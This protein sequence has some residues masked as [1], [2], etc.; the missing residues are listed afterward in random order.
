MHRL[1]L[2]IFIALL[3]FS[4]LHLHASAQAAGLNITEIKIDGLQRVEEASVRKVLKSN[5]GYPYS[6]DMISDD[7]R[8]IYKLGYFSDVIVAKEDTDEGIRL[9]YTIRERPSIRNVKLEGN[10]DV[11]DDDIEEVLDVKKHQV[12]SYDKLKRNAEKIRNVYIDKGFFLADVDFKVKEVDE[13][14]VDVV[15]VMN[16][17]AKV[18]VKKIILQGNKKI[19]DKE[20]LGVMMTKVADPFSFINNSGKFRQEILERDAFMIGNYYAD[21]GYINAKVSPPEV[22]ISPDRRWIYLTIKIQEGESYNMGEVDFQGELIFPKENLHKMM[23]LKKGEVFNRSIF[24]R[25]MEAVANLYKDKGY[26]YANVTPLTT[27]HK[28]E[29]IVDVVFDIERGQKVYIERI[30]IVGNTK[31][32]DKVIRREMRISEGDLYSATGINQ[33]KRRIYQ[34]GYF[35]TV[36]VTERP[37]SGPDNIILTV[38]VK[39]QRTGTFQLGFGFSSLENFVFQSQISQNNLLGRGQTLSLNAQVSGVR[40]QFQL[41]FFEP[42]T[43]DTKIQTGFTVFN[44]SY[45]YPRQGDFGTYSRTMWGGDFTI[46]YPFWDDVALYL[47]YE[48]KRVDMDVDNLVHLHLFKDGL[49][50]SFT[51]TAQWDTRDNRLYPTDGMLHRFSVEYADS[52]TG[53]D[54][55]FLKLTLLDNIFIPIWWKFVFKLNLEIGYVTSLE[56]PFADKRGGKDF[57]GVPLAERYLLGGIYSI[58]GFEYGSISPSIDVIPQDDPAGYPVRYRIGGNKQLITNWEIEFPV[59]EQAGVK[60]VFFFDAGNTWAEDEQFF[61]LGQSDVNEWDL[62]L[63]LYMSCGFG[64]R[65]YS[66]MGPLRFEWGIPITK[67]PED[68]NISFEFSI[69]NVF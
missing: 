52:Y 44:Q 34:L 49:T 65:W 16:E 23:T 11:K 39:E 6:S 26:A 4:S 53:S 67:R 68:D 37:G 63:G 47:T 24:M 17:R 18:Q 59:I 9:I 36:D 57:P 15:F 64:F 27:E 41:H 48:I 20:L 22:Y 29:R 51:G 42:Y 31:T 40:K 30:E 62:P 54:I 38:K 56:E 8:A 21:H 61:Y 2:I 19:P 35:E 3:L 25:D 43:F 50:S 33:S 60:W 14:R 12:L 58:R 5:E 46:G 69:G 45:T 7:I 10:D 32:R 13:N 28:E 55:E 66:P 1:L